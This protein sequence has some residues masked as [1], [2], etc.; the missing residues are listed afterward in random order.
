[1]VRFRA[2]VRLGL[3]VA[4]L[5]DGLLRRLGCRAALHTRPAMTARVKLGFGFGFGFGF[6]L[7]CEGG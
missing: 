6:G 7:G 2:R 3:G 4:N 1:M 5:N